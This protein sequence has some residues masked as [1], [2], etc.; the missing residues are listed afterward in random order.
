MNLQ[1]K[2]DS[3]EA[4]EAAEMLG[5]DIVYLEYYAWPHTFSSTAGPFGGI[6]GQSM[7]TF[8][9]EAWA[10][11]SSAVVFCN[12]RVIDRTDVFTREWEYRRGTRRKPAKEGE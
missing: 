12:G 7:S 3:K 10:Y 9:L 5:V 8:T 1:S 6:G 2:R 4:A 11:G